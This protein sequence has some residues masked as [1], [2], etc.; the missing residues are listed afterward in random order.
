MAIDI[1]ILRKQVREYILKV[2]TEIFFDKEDHIYRRISDDYFLT[3]VTTILGVRNKEFLKW[4]SVKE[5]VKY[6]G[7]FDKKEESKE[8]KQNLAKRFLEIKSLDV[9]AYWK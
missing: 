7:W 5:G 1:D 2:E 3:G 4:W 9:N 6:L 8:A